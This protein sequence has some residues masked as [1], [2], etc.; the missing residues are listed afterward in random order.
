MTYV[1]STKSYEKLLHKKFHESSDTLI[2]RTAVCVSTCQLS[3]LCSTIE[4]FKDGSR[5]CPMFYNVCYHTNTRTDIFSFCK[6]TWK[7]SFCFWTAFFGAQMNAFI[8]VIMYMYYGL[9]ACGPKFQKYLWWKR[10]LTIL[11]LV[12]EISPFTSEII[13]SK[14]ISFCRAL[15]QMLSF[16]KVLSCLI[17]AAQVKISIFLSEIKQLK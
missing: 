8:H 15:E 14:S 9:A 4:Y 5:T 10:Y 11:Q 12:S 7:S 13:V 1:C 2:A 16:S 17:L 3:G 6:I